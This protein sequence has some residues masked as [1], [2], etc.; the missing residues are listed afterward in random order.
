MFGVLINY[1]LSKSK[2]MPDLTCEEKVGFNGGFLG[3]L[4]KESLPA[5]DASSESH[6][7]YSGHKKRV[8][9][10]SLGLGSYQMLIVDL[11]KR[12]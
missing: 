1:K 7:L 6:I 11:T 4:T 12:E 8:I 2:T 3:H 9:W 10:C 5:I